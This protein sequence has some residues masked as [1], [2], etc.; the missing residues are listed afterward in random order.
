LNRK[1]SRT[2]LLS[3][4]AAVFALGATLNLFAQTA[5]SEPK[6]KGKPVKLKPPDGFMP[7]EFPE[8]RAG[9]LLLDP[10][11]PDGIFIVYPKAED[12]PDVLPNLLKSMV[13]GMFFHDEK[14]QVPW[15]AAP[16]A[17]HPGIENETG[18]LYSASNNE[19]EIQLA[20]YTRTLGA[21]TVVYGY[22]AMRHKSG[23][24]KDDAPF[25]DTTGKG[26]ETFDKF[27]RSIQE[28]K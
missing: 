1:T 27:S 4:T 16:L 10:K 9:M 12:G 13:A 19:T 3:L 22:Y 25:I 2:L 11:R 21:T 23:K 28:S 15:T 7:A 24:H 5:Q 17:A 18:L 26:A 14:A 8:K 20:F 6:D